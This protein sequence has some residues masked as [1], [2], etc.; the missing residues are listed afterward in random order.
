[1]LADSLLFVPCTGEAASAGWPFTW[2]LGEFLE[3]VA[4]WLFGPADGAG[5]IRMDAGVHQRMADR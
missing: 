3:M 1:M 4:A 2:S 5:R